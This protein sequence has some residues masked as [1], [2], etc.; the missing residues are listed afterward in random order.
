MNQVHILSQIYLAITTAPEILTA[1]FIEQ[2]LTHVLP[3]AESEADDDAVEDAINK[4]Y[5]QFTDVRNKIKALKCKS[6]DDYEATSTPGYTTITNNY[7]DIKKLEKILKTRIQKA[8]DSSASN[9]KN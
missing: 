5:R 6:I 7:P 1:P 3:L 8:S 2:L 4:I 9:D